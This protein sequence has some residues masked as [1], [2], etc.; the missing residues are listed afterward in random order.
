[1]TDSYNIFMAATMLPFV[2][3]FYAELARGE[4]WLAALI[5]CS[6]LSSALYHL[7]ESQKHRLRGLSGSRL[8][9]AWWNQIL[10]NADRFFAGCLF[11]VKFARVQQFTAPLVCTALF[12]LAIM[13][14]SETVYRRELN[15]YIV[16]HAAW[17][18]L[19]AALLVLA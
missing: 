10:I 16:T 8:S 9:S 13:A 11:L 19:A 18:F 7:H 14:V 12:A 15:G 1:M 5:A 2:V 17:H 6:G 4:V 3:P